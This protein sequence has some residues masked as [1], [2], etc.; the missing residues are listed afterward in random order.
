MEKTVQEKNSSL[1]YKKW[2]LA[3]SSSSSWC[4]IRELDLASRSRFP[5][6]FT[7]WFQKESES[8][9]LESSQRSLKSKLK[10]LMR[11]KHKWQ[12]CL[13]TCRNLRKTLSKKPKWMIKSWL[14]SRRKSISKTWLMQGRKSKTLLK[15]SRRLAWWSCELFHDPTWWSKSAYK[16]CSLWEATNS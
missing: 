4:G 11:L 1:S 13:K 6:S 9:S 5:V 15:L 10:L 3:I 2:T 8:Y 16:S 14:Y 12:E 7:E